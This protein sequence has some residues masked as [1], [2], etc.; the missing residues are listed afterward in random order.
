MTSTTQA[1]SRPSNDQRRRVFGVGEPV[2]GYIDLSYRPT[3]PHLSLGEVDGCCHIIQSDANGPEQFPGSV[4]SN[5]VSYPGQV[6]MGVAVWILVD[7]PNLNFPKE[8]TCPFNVRDDLLS[9][10]LA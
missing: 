5:Q 3:S 10:G 4:T 7:G 2:E 9:E 8:F 1:R 6:A